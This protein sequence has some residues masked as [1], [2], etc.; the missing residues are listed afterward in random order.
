MTALETVRDR[1]VDP[2]AREPDGR[3]LNLVWFGGAML[4][5]GLSLYYLV[6]HDSSVSPFELLFVL[7]FTLGGV[8]ESLPAGRRRA[9]FGARIATLAIAGVMGGLSFVA[10][11][12]GPDVLF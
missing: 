3:P 2:L 9:A 11:L 12:G 7:M 8:A 6:V 5:A 1:V 10:L 4:M